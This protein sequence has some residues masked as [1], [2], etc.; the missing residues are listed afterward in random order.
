MAEERV[1]ACWV[2]CCK[3]WLVE[4]QTYGAVVRHLQDE[5]S[6]HMAVFG[7]IAGLEELKRVQRW[8]G[9]CGV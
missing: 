4:V 8:V 2:K 3:K 7:N 1:C 9:M 6:F 5:L